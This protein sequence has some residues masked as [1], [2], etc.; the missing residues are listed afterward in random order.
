MPS[1][2]SRRLGPVGHALYNAVYWPY[3]ICTIVL[4]FFPAALLWALTFWQRPRRWL[5]AYTC[6][7]GAHYLAW[8]PLAG[9]RVEGRERAQGLGPCVFVVNHQSMVDIL[10]VYELHLP[11]SWVSKVE[12]F[13]A[14][15]LGWNMWLNGYVPLKRGHLPSIRRMLRR[16]EAHLREGSS[17]CVFPE[18]TRSVDGNLRD[19][20]RGAFWIAVRN[21][22]PI[23]PVV[24]D[25]TFEIL[26]KGS[27]G[28]RP[29]PVTLSVL[30]P[31]F[32]EQAGGDDRRL[33][34]LTKDR[35]RE[36]LLRVRRSP[37]SELSEAAASELG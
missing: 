3:L 17:L 5:H 25:G 6:Y 1:E 10:A 2:R 26:A 8:A 7:W 34:E 21:R 15:F 35:M 30:E 22:V 19:F 11:F 31:I 16:C 23:V 32:P 9:I 18:G 27:F 14:P 28:I 29:Q 37:A 36:Q 13:Y 24:V 12:N 33:R 20:Y 4:L